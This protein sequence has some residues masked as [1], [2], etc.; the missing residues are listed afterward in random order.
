MKS[1]III[2]R[3]NDIINFDE[4]NTNNSEFS[5]NKMWAPSISSKIKQFIWKTCNNA[6]PTRDHLIKSNVNIDPI[7]SVCNEQIKSNLQV[8][9]TCPI[10]E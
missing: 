9:V 7:C 8:L 6:L 5:Y 2:E 4:E 1:Q 3:N 10:I